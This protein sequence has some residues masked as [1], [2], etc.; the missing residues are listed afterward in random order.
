MATLPGPYEILELDDEGSLTTRIQKWEVG[1][2]TIHPSYQPEG[3]IIRALRIH[4]LEADKEY[5]PYYWDITSQT[6][7]AQLVPYLEQTHFEIRRYTITKHGSGP[8]A[9]F[10]L[11]VR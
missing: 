3:K 5:F 4:V 7:L 10:S 2:V 11:V 8:R 9:R 1:E 6:L